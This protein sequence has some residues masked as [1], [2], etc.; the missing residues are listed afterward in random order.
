MERKIRKKVTGFQTQDGAGVRLVRVLG[1][2]TVEEYDPFLM[3]DSFD[4]KNPE[5]YTKGFPFHPHRGIETITYLAKGRI[6]HRDHLGNEGVIGEGEA[7]WMTAGSG[8]MHEEMPEASEEMLG[9]QLWLNLPAVHKMTSPEYNDI[10]DIQE[11]QEETA[12]VRVVSGEYKNVKGFQGKYIPADF[13]DIRL[14]ENKEFTF[15]TKAENEVYLFLLKGDLEVEGEFCKEKTAVAFERGE[16]V[17]VKSVEGKPAEFLVFSAPK[18][19]EPVVWGGPIVMNTQEEL[20]QA[21]Y[22]LQTGTFVKEDVRK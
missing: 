8:I 17:S 15:Q 9:V 11:V 22:E 13:Y 14:I 20:R 2:E 1:L 7:Q 10:R 19:S 5:D 18:L 21:F 3:L 12:L 4:S 6:K 16:A